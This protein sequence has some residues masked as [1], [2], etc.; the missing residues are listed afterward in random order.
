LEREPEGEVKNQISPDDH[1][2][3]P[4]Y[5]SVPLWEKLKPLAREKRHEPTP[6]ENALWRR[7]RNRHIGNA[8]FRRQ[9]AIERFIVDFYCI[10]AGLVIEIDGSIHEYTVE[11]DVI[12][13]EYLEGLGLRVLRFTNDQVLGEM[14]SVLEKINELLQLQPRRSIPN[15]GKPKASD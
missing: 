6:A 11:E 4:A 3:A 8:K 14:N 10:E 7:L 9:H 1:L 13:Q 15:K 12:R 5:S 2:P